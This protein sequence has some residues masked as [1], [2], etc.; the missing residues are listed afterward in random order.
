MTSRTT[1]TSKRAN[2]RKRSAG[3]AGVSSPQL[4]SP[5][6]PA[7]PVTLP[8]P[9]NLSSSSDLQ[10]IVKPISG[11]TTPTIPGRSV[12]SATAARNVPAFLNK[13]YNMVNDASTDELIHWGP[14]GTTFIVKRHEDFAKDVLPRFFKHNNFASFVRQL[15][16]YGFHKIPHLQQGVLH[17]D[18]EPEIWEFCNPNFQRNQPDLLCLVTRKK[19]REGV[20][21]KDAAALDMNYIIQE[22]AAIKRHQL[23]ISSDLKNI[24]RENQ[25]LWSESVS[26]R[27]RYQRQ[28]E[29]IDKILRFLASVFSTKRQPLMNKKRRLLLGDKPG[30]L[31]PESDTGDDEQGWCKHNPQIY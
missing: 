3:S 2:P 17:N 14:D 26:I 23:T 4:P 27:D 13:L 8:V 30:G 16:M 10:R 5:S 18:G 29:T 9:T 28:Q 1:G 6:F 25:V 7:L 12:L 21:E 31:P 15:N 24:Q 19:G 22:I 11:S 20:E